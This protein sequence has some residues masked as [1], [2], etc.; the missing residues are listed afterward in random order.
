VLNTYVLSE[1]CFVM[2]KSMKDLIRAPMS[3]THEYEIPNFANLNCYVL[4]M[5]GNKVSE[6][7]IK[8]I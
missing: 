1:N 8:N 4:N 6:N 3:L 7:P 2:S 5:F